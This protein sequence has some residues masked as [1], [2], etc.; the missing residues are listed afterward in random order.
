M[1]HPTPSLAPAA[2][3][4]RTGARPL[5]RWLLVAGVVGLLG[6]GIDLLQSPPARALPAPQAWAASVPLDHS[7][8]TKLDEHAALEPGLSVAAY[9]RSAA[10]D[11]APAP[12]AATQPPMAEDMLEP[13]ASVAAYER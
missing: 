5:P 12:A 13:G 4:R 1:S 11:A 8:V 3:R 7:A 2:T 9:D 6:V 10:T